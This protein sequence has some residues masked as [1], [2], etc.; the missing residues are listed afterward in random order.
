MENENNVM[1]PVELE[2]APNSPEATPDISQEE[3][4]MVPKTN[5]FK[6]LWE[7]IKWVAKA[8]VNLVEAGIA[9]VLYGNKAAIQDLQKM[10]EMIESPIYKEK[11]EK[12]KE[13]K[14]EEQEKEEHEEEIEK[15]EVEKEEIEENLNKEVTDEDIKCQEY[16]DE[17][18]ENERPF[19]DLVESMGFEYE[20][21]PDKVGVITL[22]KTNRE[23]GNT[24]KVDINLKDFKNLDSNGI[25]KLQILFENKNSKTA[26]DENHNPKSVHVIDT[27]ELR[28]NVAILSAAMNQLYCGPKN[29][30]FEFEAY[31]QPMKMEITHSEENDFAKIITQDKNECV[32]FRPEGQKF[33]WIMKNDK[34]QETIR[35]NCLA[36]EALNA[37]EEEEI[38]SN[39]ISQ[40]IEE[41]K[42][43]SPEVNTWDKQLD[44]ILNDK[45]KE[46]Q[47]ID[48]ETQEQEKSFNVEIDEEEF[49]SEAPTE[50]LDQQEHDFDDDMLR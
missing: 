21:N 19:K 26:F 10:S 39:K 45:V 3:T 9:R 48:N 49:D 50:R 2:N 41:S 29:I 34:V 14:K 8:I 12:D 27:N 30:S 13:E 38:E 36:I 28:I 15:D 18:I 22:K 46:P 7:G 23:L 24:L 32:A 17:Y 33:F 40:I 43:I 1:D 37:I 11:I 25:N 4:V 16:F 20:N 42:K 31:K 44:K 35:D 47:S 6:K 5:L